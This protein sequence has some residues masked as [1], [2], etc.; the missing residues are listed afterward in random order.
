MEYGQQHAKISIDLVVDEP[1]AREALRAT[2]HAILFHRLFGVVKPKIIELLDVTLPA[3]AD[4]EIEQRV[5]EKVELIWRSLESGVQ[6]RGQVS[7]SF[8][9]KRPKKNWF[10]V[11]E[12]E[13]PWEE[14]VVNVEMRH[15]ST[16][17]ERV[18]LHTALAQKLVAT[19][20]TILTHTSS[21]RGRGIVPLISTAKGISPFPI[22]LVA[23]VAGEELF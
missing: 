13:V 14:W 18:E 17:N 16:S 3:V 9:E 21:E 6:K 22:Q 7:L 12:E 4:N 15:P 2:L 19:L 11:A 23:K 20:R 8:A 5:D 10:Y 1:T